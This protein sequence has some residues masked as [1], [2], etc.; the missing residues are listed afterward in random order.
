[1]SRAGFRGSRPG[2]PHDAG[3]I[4]DA[5]ATAGRACRNVRRMSA[6][7]RTRSCASVWDRD[8][9]RTRV[10]LGKRP[11]GFDLSDGV[12][13]G[14]APVRL[15]V[16]RYGDTGQDTGQSRPRLAKPLHAVAALDGTIPRGFPCHRDFC[17]VHCDGACAG[18]RAGPALRQGANR[19]TQRPLPRVAGISPRHRSGRHAAEGNCGFDAGKPQ[20]QSVRAANC[21][22]AG[23]GA[24][25]LARAIS[26]RARQSVAAW[27]LDALAVGR[28]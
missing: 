27:V 22:A 28:L 19:S 6:V 15:K 20:S 4:R 9:K 11:R 2:E 25:L 8:P 1:M 23:T 3:I 17:C 14:V 5:G 24:C 18:D 12:H 21:A 13:A 16:K 7:G 10:R 26:P